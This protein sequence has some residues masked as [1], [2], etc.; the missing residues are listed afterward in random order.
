M[1]RER[2]AKNVA[3]AKDSCIFLMPI[4]NDHMYYIVMIR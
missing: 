3:S 2:I 1:E 4:D